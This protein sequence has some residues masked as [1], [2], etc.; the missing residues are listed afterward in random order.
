MP[1]KT[2]LSDVD[3]IT[4]VREAFE[5]F[6]KFCVQ[7]GWEDDEIFWWVAGVVNKKMEAE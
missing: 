3:D 5:D 1:K 7:L 4:Q 2:I 6:R